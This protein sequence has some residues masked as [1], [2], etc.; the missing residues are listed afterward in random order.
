MSTA[1]VVGDN[2][3]ELRGRRSQVWLAARL[4]VTQATVS[5]W[6]LGN[7]LPVE[8]NLDGLAV[9][10]ECKVADL[11]TPKFGAAVARAAEA[12]AS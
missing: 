4:G 11:F 6:E 3:R 7:C 2:I 10:F 9:V 12:R 5:S 1:A 8:E